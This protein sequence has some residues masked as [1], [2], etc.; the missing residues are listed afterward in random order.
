M[1]TV[2]VV[3]L[4]AVVLAG[5]AA[6]WT[7]TRPKPAEAPPPPPVPVTAAEAK[8]GVVPVYLRGVGTVRALNAVEIRPQVGGVLLELPVREGDLVK[9]GDV[10]AVIDPRPYKAAVDK[11]QAQLQQDQAQLDNAQADLRRTSTLA[12][13]EFASRQQLDTQTASVARLQGV[14]AADAAAIEEAQINLSYTVLKAP[15]PGRVGLRRVDPG[16]LIQANGTGPGILSIVQE[17]PIAVLFSLPDSEL[18]QVRRA[19]A[20]GALPVLADS[21]D[22]SSELAQGSLLTP[23]NAVDSASGTIQLKATF[24]NADAALTSGQFVSVRLQVDTVQ[25]VSV[26]HQAIQHGQDGLFVYA[27]KPDR[28]AERRAVQVAYDDGKQSVLSGGLDGGAQVVI[29]GQTR[30][31]SG[32]RVVLPGEEQAPG[33]PGQTTQQSAQ[34]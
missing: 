6:G 20:K 8:P 10:L 9:T 14:V 19:M 31:G 3:V 13:S 24:A 18:P 25:G 15:M 12:R 21:S 34:K 26:P 29:A 32:T 17:Q 4:G 33:K 22:Q 27:I 28:T 7:L 5:G 2:Y 30:V 23:D 1:R 16:N 11:A